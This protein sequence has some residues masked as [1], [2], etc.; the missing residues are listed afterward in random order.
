MK[1]LDFDPL[2]IPELTGKMITADYGLGAKAPEAE[3][4][5]EGTG[6]QIKDIKLIDCSGYF[7][8]TVYKACGVKCPDGSAAQLAWLRK[9]G[10]KETT[11][12][13]GKLM[14]GVLR[15]AVRPQQPGNTGGARGRHITW[16]LNGRTFESS[17]TTKGPG[18]RPW[19]GRGWQSQCK[20]FVVAYPK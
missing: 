15:A 12:A 11:V 9:E 2:V 5:R 17:P 4:F 1:T 13:A 16:I 10:F 6:A 8:L 14:D 19:T 20:V 7:R 18:S 3:Y